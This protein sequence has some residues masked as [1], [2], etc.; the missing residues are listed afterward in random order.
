M[1]RKAEKNREKMKKSV[2]KSAEKLYDK[3]NGILGNVKEET[4]C[5]RLDRMMQNL[6]HV[7]L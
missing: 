7:L 4:F 2:D 6:L 5:W 1:K 3:L